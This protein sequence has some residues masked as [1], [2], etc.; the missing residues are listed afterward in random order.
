MRGT[1]WKTKSHTAFR[2]VN[3]NFYETAITAGVDIIETEA[4]IRIYGRAY[5][6][7]MAID[8]IYWDIAE[9]P[10]NKK[11]PLSFR[12]WAAFKVEPAMFS[13]TTLI[14]SSIKSAEQAV[15]IYL[16]WQA[17]QFENMK[18]KME[19]Q[20]FSEL[21]ASMALSRHKPSFYATGLICSHIAEGNPEKALEIARKYAPTELKNLYHAGDPNH[22]V[23]FYELTIL[24][25]TGKLP[26]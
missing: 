4:H 20:P 9:L 15:E 22:R 16:N 6:K 7:P 10:D 25:L 13:G 14:E 8:P 3:D 18:E 1:G 17:D 23:N 12:A 2:C 11:K 21:Y 5:A 19:A 24:H 26:S